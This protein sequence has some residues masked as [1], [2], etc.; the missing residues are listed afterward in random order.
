MIVDAV[1]GARAGSAHWPR[2]PGLGREQLQTTT[3]PDF[4]HPKMPRHE[5]LPLLT[6]VPIFPPSGW[7]DC[8]SSFRRSLKANQPAPIR[9]GDGF[10]PAQHIEFGENAAEMRLHRRLADAEIRSDFLVAPTLGEQL[11][12]IHFAS[13]Q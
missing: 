13:C 11:Q 4:T 5:G 1:C 7:A 2:G 8:V 10:R 9:D 3:G 12:D 6:R